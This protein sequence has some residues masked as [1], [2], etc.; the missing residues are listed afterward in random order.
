VGR[1]LLLA[2]LQLLRTRLSGHYQNTLQTKRQEPEFYIHVFRIEYII[3]RK[4]NTFSL[5]NKSFK[6]MVCQESVLG[7]YCAKHEK[8]CPTY[9]ITTIK[10]LLGETLDLKHLP[11]NMDDCRLSWFCRCN[12]HTFGSGS[13]SY[14][15]FTCL[16]DNKTMV[17]KI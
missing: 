4:H 15:L 6:I 10:Q 16:S 3:E 11:D 5:H 7:Y 12:L 1:A 17:F 9:T 14:I 8:R 13:G 2:S